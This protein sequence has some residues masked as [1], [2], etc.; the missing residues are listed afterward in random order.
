MV[1]KIPHSAYDELKPQPAEGL[2]RDYFIDRNWA[3]ENYL[4]MIERQ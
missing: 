2:D 4:T 3:I 1:A